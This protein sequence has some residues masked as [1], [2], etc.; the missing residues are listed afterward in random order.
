MTSTPTD[1]FKNYQHLL[2]ADQLDQLQQACA[3][4]LAPALRV[5][6][7]KIDLDT[8]RSTWPI[9]YGWQVQPVP[10][11]EAGWQIT[12]NAES[13][14]RTIEHRTGF[15][16]LQDAASMLPAE[17]F[18]VRDRVSVD[19]RY[20]GVAR[21]ED[22][23]PRGQ[24][25]RSGCD[26]RQRQQLG[27]HRRAALESADVGIVLDRV[28]QLSRRTLSAN[29]FPTRSIVSCSTRRAA[30]RVCAPPSGARRASCRRPS[31]CNCSGGRSNCWRVLSTP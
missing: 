20:G 15:Y 19:P 21:R 2:S 18:D 22:H 16:Y 27:P 13:L 10:F 12:G 31:G 3:R 4:P 14:S 26:P 7:L 9:E 28:D 23:A 6:T 1:R 11:C 25:R 29:G 24:D 17:M 5:N 30:A 8:A